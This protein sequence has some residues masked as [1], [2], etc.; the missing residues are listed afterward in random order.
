MLMALSVAQCRAILGEDADGKTDEQIENLRGSTA[1]I[2][3]EL[4]NQLQA[5][6]K[7]DPEAFRW[8]A[9]AHENGEGDEAHDFNAHDDGDEL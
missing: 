3:N 8:S 4:Y 6:W 5:D 1:A 2:A 9:Y 7:A